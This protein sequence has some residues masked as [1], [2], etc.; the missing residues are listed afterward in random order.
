MSKAATGKNFLL[1]PVSELQA[2]P[3]NAK[4]HPAKQIAAIKGSMREFGFTSPIL[5][6]L[7]DGGLIVAGHGRRTAATEIY[8][9]GGSLRLP[10]GEKLPDGMVPVI[11]MSGLTEVQRRAY[12]IAD[13]KLAEIA[14]WD[15][16]LLRTELVFLE[17]EA[18]LSLSDL[19]FSTEDLNSLLGGGDPGKGDA[20]GKEVYTR[21][22]Q[23]PIYEPK[24]DK[25]EVAEL[26]DDSKAQELIDEIRAADLPEDISQF[27]T[28]AAERHTVF[29]FRRI[30]D[31]YAAADADTQDLME[32]SALVIIDFD[33]AI[34]NGFVKLSKTLG[35]LVERDH[36]DA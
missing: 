3:R 18:D 25:P 8:E 17:N 36:P 23:P 32:R 22:I 4:V 34:E 6:D 5:A 21:K 16:D 14:E 9:E 13:N 26:Y 19:G 31:F 15:E 35:G 20:G 24:G 7:D 12:M 27:L 11:D 33:K 30:A 1:V 10:S 29:N 28:K 2:D